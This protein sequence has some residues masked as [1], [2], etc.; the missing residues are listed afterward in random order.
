MPCPNGVDIPTNFQLLN[1]AKT[2]GTG[3]YGLNR[4]LYTDMAEPRRGGSCVAC[5][6]CAPQCPQEIA[7]PDE[8][9]TVHEYFTKKDAKE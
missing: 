1:D 8:L 7:V 2:F 3:H 6:E 4:N 9:Q 5:G